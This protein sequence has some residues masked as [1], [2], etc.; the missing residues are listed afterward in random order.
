MGCGGDKQEANGRSFVLSRPFTS[1]LCIIVDAASLSSLLCRLGEEA[2]N[3][4]SKH[5][6]LLWMKIYNVELFR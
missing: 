6:K 3:I 2:Q 5:R 4:F 1:Q